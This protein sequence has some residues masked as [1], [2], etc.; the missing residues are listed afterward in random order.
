MFERLRG[1]LAKQRG[2]RHVA[3]PAPPPTLEERVVRANATS[4]ENPALWNFQLAAV[5]GDA[6]IGDGTTDDRGFAGSTVPSVDIGFEP[7]PGALTGQQVFR[8]RVRAQ[9]VVTAQPALRLRVVRNGNLVNG[10]VTEVL[11]T[12]W[13]LL[14]LTADAAELGSENGADVR[15]RIEHL[16][17]TPGAGYT[18]IDAVDVQ[19]RCLV[20]E[21]SG[22]GS[23]P[24][25]GGGTWPAGWGDRPARGTHLGI[26]QPFS[27]S[28]DGNGNLV[29]QPLRDYEAWLGRKADIAKVWPNSASTGGAGTG[30]VDWDAIGGGANAAD[31]FFGG[32]LDEVNP[33]RA[34]DP[35]YW[36]VTLPVVLALGAVPVSHQNSQSSTGQWRRP[37]IWSEIARG[38]FDLYYQRLFRKLAYKCGQIGRDPRTV[39][40]RWC[41]EANGNWYPHSVGPDKASFATAWRRCMDIMRSSVAAVLGAGKT[42]MIEF[43]PAGHLR[44]GNGASERLQNIYPGG[45]WVDICGLGIH[46]QVGITVQ[47]DWNQYLTYP[48]TIAGTPFEGIHDWFD[49][50]VAQGKWVGTSEIES[51]YNARQYFPKT[52]NMS[53]MWTSGF[54]LLRKRYDGKFVYCCYLWTGDSHLKRTDSW[55]EPYRLLYK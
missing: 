36:P 48:A 41:W 38:D 35:T 33:K 37:G 49:F 46:D 16:N 34:L 19:W 13:V 30:W 44:F 55:G 25:S 42:F 10:N 52:Q 18:Q 40:L 15:L 51:N 27:F 20:P 39:V 23:P 29:W 26:G 28:Y 47:A 45:D 1:L 32:Q 2:L 43:G 50:A 53:V 22:G 5:I 21:G 12:S 8:A 17:G 54:E 4:S 6:S 3:P 9:G 11:T 31:S 7:A 14:T 24:V